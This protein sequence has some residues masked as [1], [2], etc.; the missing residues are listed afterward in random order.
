MAIKTITVSMNGDSIQ[1]TPDPLVLKKIQNDKAKWEG[2]PSNL[3]FYVCFREKTPF[4]HRH[5]HKNRPQSGPIEIE[6][7]QTEEYFKYSVEIGDIVLDPGII[8]SR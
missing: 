8:I 3:D 1:V 4:K 6:L 2:N 5:F 7:S